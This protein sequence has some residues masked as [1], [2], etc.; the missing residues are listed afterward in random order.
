MYFLLIVIPVCEIWHPLVVEIETYRPV[1]CHKL[2]LLFKMLQICYKCY[3]QAKVHHWMIGQ[4]IAGPYEGWYL[5]QRYLGDA[6]KLS[7]HLP[8]WQHLPSR[9]EIPMLLPV[10]CRLS[11]CCLLHALDTCDHPKTL[12]SLFGYTYGIYFSFSTWRAIRRFEGKM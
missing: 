8:V 5:A 1:L 2:Y 9:T 7:L 6:L 11:Y 10:S 12:I 3:K 4:L